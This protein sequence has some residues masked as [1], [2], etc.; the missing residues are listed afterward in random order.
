MM[1]EGFLKKKLSCFCG[2][3][4]HSCL[5]EQQQTQYFKKDR[6]VLKSTLVNAEVMEKTVLNI[7]SIQKQN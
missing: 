7:N 3:H 5:P 1:W 2:K 4:Q 6:P